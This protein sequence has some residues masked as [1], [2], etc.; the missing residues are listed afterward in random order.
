MGIA[1]EFVHNYQDYVEIPGLGEAFHE[2]HR[3]DLPGVIGHW[4]R[5]K[6]SRVAHA[7]RFRLL[8]HKAGLHL[9]TD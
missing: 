2:I 6:E 5:L 4:K 7:L 8:A 1:G 9:L 3:N